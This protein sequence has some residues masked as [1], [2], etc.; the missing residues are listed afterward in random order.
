[1][2]EKLGLDESGLLPMLLPFD[3]SA[4]FLRHSPSD[5]TGHKQLLDFFRRSL[6]NDRIE[7][8]EDFFDT[9][10]ASGKA[11]VLLDGLDEV[12]DPDLRRRVA[13]LVEGLCRRTRTAAM[14]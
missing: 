3:R 9:W 10:L 5:G 6:A 14:W 13:R 2:S 4:T 11:V 12:A 7:V 8:P 1:M